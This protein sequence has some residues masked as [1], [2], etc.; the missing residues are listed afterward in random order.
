MASRALAAHRRDSASVHPFP[1]PS[2]VAIVLGAQWGDEVSETNN[3]NPTLDTSLQGKGKLVD[4]LASEA[5]IVCRCQVN[6]H[7]FAVLVSTDVH[8]VAT[9]R[10]IV[11]SSKVW[12]T[13]FT[14]FRR[15]STYR[16]A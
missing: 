3:A 6:C 5:D 11:S 13:I 4:L 12:N 9:M 15:A 14:C 2:P 8:R 10:D 16:I 1:S 7:V